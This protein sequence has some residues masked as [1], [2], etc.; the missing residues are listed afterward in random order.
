MSPTAFLGLAKLKSD[1]EEKTKDKDDDLN[2]DED[3]LSDFNLL[4]TLAG[5]DLITGPRLPPMPTLPPQPGNLLPL[6]DELNLS[7]SL[8]RQ[9]KKQVKQSQLQSQ[10]QQAAGGGRNGEGFI[11]GIPGKDYPDFKAIPATE[12]TCENFILEGFYA[13]TFTSCQV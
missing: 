12:F 9:L 4:E 5:L 8:L 6:L 2:I 3:D 11:P 7:P 10:R 13:D 1:R